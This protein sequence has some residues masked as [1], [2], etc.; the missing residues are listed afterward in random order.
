MGSADEKGPGGGGDEGCRRPLRPGPGPGATVPLGG[1]QG[2]AAGLS[3]PPPC[4]SLPCGLGAKGTVAGAGP[5]RGGSRETER[6]PLCGTLGR[7]QCRAGEP[8]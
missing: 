3:S 8:V 4:L 2:R 7:G 5:A 6:P 1:A